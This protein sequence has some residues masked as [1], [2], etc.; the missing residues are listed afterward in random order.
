MNYQPRGEEDHPIRDELP[1]CGKPVPKGSRKD[2]E[3]CS[4]TMRAET[5]V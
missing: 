1:M 3:V 2:S 4:A 5:A